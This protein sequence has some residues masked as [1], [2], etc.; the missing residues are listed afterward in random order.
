V[1]EAA[2]ASA[3]VDAEL[4]QRLDQ[5]ERR[6][7]DA[8]PHPKRRRDWLAGRMVAK[9]AV[10]HVLGRDHAGWLDLR[11]ERGADGAPRVFRD[12]ASPAQVSIAHSAD[13]AI[14]AASDTTPL[15]VDVERVSPAVEEIA[16]SFCLPG[17]LE[18]ARAS[19]SHTR[20]Q[21]LT[22]LWTAKEAARKL[23]GPHAC[24][25]T[26]LRVA[27]REAHGAYTR[28]LV[29]GPSARFRVVVFERQ[30]SGYAIAVE[31]KP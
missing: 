30:G 3:D 5:V 25:M 24:A 2:L 9:S 8:L 13:V 28:L 21:V 31:V 17:E 4:A 1:A 16:D 18:I 29:N 27:G 7:L 10:R 15:G 20:A 6:E 19:E 23:A 11:I 12:G 14:A 22:V 26:D